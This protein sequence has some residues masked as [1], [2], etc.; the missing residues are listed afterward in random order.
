MRDAQ[1]L[2][3]YLVNSN[4]SALILNLLAEDCKCNAPDLRCVL[5]KSSMG[6]M[7]QG[8]RLVYEG[9]ARL[10]AWRSDDHDKSAQCNLNPDI[11]AVLRAHWFILA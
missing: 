3:P 5:R 9:Y 4:S 8:L 11:V 1:T 2:H 6:C 10:E 7:I